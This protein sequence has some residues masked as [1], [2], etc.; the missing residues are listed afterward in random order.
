MKSTAALLNQT[1][2]ELRR[3]GYSVF[4]ISRDYQARITGFAPFTEW[5]FENIEFDGFRAPECKLQEAKA[6][7]DQFFDARTGLPKKFFAI[8][9][10][11]RMLNQARIQSKIVETNPPARLTW[12]FMQP[13]S[14]DY[15]S[16]IFSHEKL[17][18]ESSLRP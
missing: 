15:F 3:R 7:Y 14:H 13:V 9:G 5:K 16:K 17:P 1:N 12:H 18:I 2:T 11:P 8:F 10:V 4:F 6:R